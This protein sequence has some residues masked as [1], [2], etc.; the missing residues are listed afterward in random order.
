MTRQ[1]TTRKKGKRPGRPAKLP[2][3][4]AA[5]IAD[6]E[7]REQLERQLKTPDRPTSLDIIRLEL[8]KRK[9]KDEDEDEDEEGLEKKPTELTKQRVI[10]LM[11]QEAERRGKDGSHLL[12]ADNIEAVARWM[13]DPGA[14]S[15]EAAMSPRDKSK[16]SKK[17]KR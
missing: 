9:E 14:S 17:K 12:T 2:S 6:D 3:D 15:Y 4:L 7:M 8:S 13:R 16:G 11:K 1:P 5:R 10:K